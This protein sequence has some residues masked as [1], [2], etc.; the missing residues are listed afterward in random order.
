MSIERMLVVQGILLGGFLA[1]FPTHR[2]LSLGLRL[3]IAMALFISVFFANAIAT[4]T[5]TNVITRDNADGIIWIIL[6]GALRGLGGAMLLFPWMFNLSFSAPFSCIA[7]RIVYL[8][9]LQAS[10]FFRGSGKQA[11]TVHEEQPVRFQFTI[12]QTMNLTGIAAVSF[13]QLAEFI[14]IDAF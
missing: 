3:V 7:I 12:L 6:D 11:S 10:A 13:W 1:V 2:K 5:A 9:I 14:R 4:G 8:G